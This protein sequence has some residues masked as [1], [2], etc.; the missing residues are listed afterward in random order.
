MKPATDFTDGKSCPRGVADEEAA[1]G[2]G[3]AQLAADDVAREEVAVAMDLRADAP[4]FAVAAQAAGADL[5]RAMGSAGLRPAISGFHA[6]NNRE[7]Q[8]ASGATPDAARGA[9]VLPFLER[10]PAGHRFADAFHP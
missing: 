10:A 3:H 2:V 9:R 8:R 7:T 4:G 6:G 5:Q 1:F